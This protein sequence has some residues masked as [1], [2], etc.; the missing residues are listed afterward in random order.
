MNIFTGKISNRLRLNRNI[1]F[2]KISYSILKHP[3]YSEYERTTKKNF[4]VENVRS[5]IKV[6]GQYPTD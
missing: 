1:L 5:D 2:Y 3:V 6:S 4:I